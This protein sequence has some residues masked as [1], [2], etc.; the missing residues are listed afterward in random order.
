MY[1]QQTQ[2]LF[3]NLLPYKNDLNKQQ[4][5]ISSLAFQS[6]NLNAIKKKALQQ[7]GPIIGVLLSISAFISQYGLKRNDVMKSIE[8]G[9]IVLKG[10]KIDDKNPINIK[11]LDNY[12]QKIKINEK[13][14]K[15]YHLAK[16]LGVNQHAINW[17]IAKGH[18]VTNEDSSI[19][20]THPINRNFIEN[21]SKSTRKS[22]VNYSPENYQSLQKIL[23]RLPLEYCL[24]HGLLITDENGNINLLNEANKEF[25][26]KIKNKEITYKTFF[27]T[28]NDFT[29]KLGISKSKVLL[30]KNRGEVIY[31]ENLGFDINDPI[32]IEYMRK[33]REIQKAKEEQLLTI[34]QLKDLVGITDTSLIYYYTT[35]GRLNMNKNGLFDLTKEQNQSFIRGESP[36]KHKKRNTKR[37]NITIKRKTAEGYITQ[38][39]LAKQLGISQPTLIWHNTKGHLNYTTKK[40]YDLSDPLNI[41]FIQNFVKGE[42]YVAQDQLENEEK[43]NSIETELLNKKSKEKEIRTLTTT[44]LAN[45]SSLAISAIVKYASQGKIIKD[46]NGKFDIEHPI[47]KKFIEEYQEKSKEKIENFSPKKLAKAAKSI[48][49]MLTKRTS[50]VVYNVSKS[51]KETDEN[52]YK[53][54]LGYSLNKIIDY[55]NLPQNIQEELLELY[56]E[57][58]E[59]EPNNTYK[60]FT[61]TDKLDIKPFLPII[62][63]LI[64]N[65]NTEIDGMSFKEYRLFVENKALNF[66]EIENTKKV[67]QERENEYLEKYIDIIKNL[68]F[69]KINALNY[70]DKTPLNK[71]IDTYLYNEFL[72][73]KYNNRLVQTKREI[74]SLQKL[75]NLTENKV[76]IL[77]EKV[78]F[79]DCQI[80]DLNKS[81]YEAWKTEIDIKKVELLI[82][83]IIK[84][85]KENATESICLNNA[86]EM[87]KKSNP[88]L[89]ISKEDFIKYMEEKLHLNF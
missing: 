78:L 6:S 76:N 58:I 49:K 36:Q 51:I 42:E 79:K 39:G 24:K 14:V 62:N 67:E 86:H 53:K 48:K 4:N 61:T 34:E 12:N 60:H 50:Y 47:N 1:I 46:E 21:F 16:L 28:I 87:L 8:E 45:L 82:R 73:A 40:G 77:V 81:L 71:L 63:A 83:R 72:S 74:N 89:N 23:G 17:Y 25:F 10:S 38:V 44:E 2:F 37:K 65:K 19:D 68:Y 88:E 5:K 84:I 31:T 41:Y 66:D 64:K 57:A 30:A 75:S 69:E 59:N 22:C 7:K 3:K 26:K 15:R 27:L 55:E 80:S 32:N 11:Y 29:N 20:I 43:L 54:Y 35:I 85:Y 33:I 56:I 13:Q 52:E 9:T 70:L 18:I